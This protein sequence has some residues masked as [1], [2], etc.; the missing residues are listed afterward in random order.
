M[1]VTTTKKSFSLPTFI[2]TRLDEVSAHTGYSQSN[3]VLQA[4]T[5]YLHRYEV[6]DSL[7]KWLEWQGKVSGMFDGDGS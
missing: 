3:L 5:V 1:K 7:E 6:E 4:I 2:A